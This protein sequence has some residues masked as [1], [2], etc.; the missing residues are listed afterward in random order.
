MRTDPLLTVSRSIA[1]IGTGCEYSPLSPVNRHIHYLPATS[2]AGGKNLGALVLF[3]GPLISQFWTVGETSPGLKTIVDHPF[4]SWFLRKNAF[5]QDSIPEG[6]T[7][8][9]PYTLPPVYPTP[10]IPSPDTLPPGRNL[11]PVIPYP[12]PER[13]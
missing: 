2:F 12:T 11:E 13:T 9:S 5:K 4:A 10:W 8:Y 3:V 7:P 6:C 1:Y